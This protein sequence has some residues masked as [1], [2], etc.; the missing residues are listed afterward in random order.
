VHAQSGDPRLAI[1]A[2]DR[3]RSLSPF[4]PL[5]FGMLASR[6]LSLLRL[7]EHEEAA[8]W[9]LKA[10]SR[11]NAH[12][13][14]QAIAAI[15]LALAEQSDQARA[16]VARIRAKQPHYVA[17]DLLRAF[18]FAA[19]GERLMHAGARRIGF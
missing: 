8:R 14:I 13:H 9:A 10:V 3:S 15:S 11:P 19:D 1:D 18:R 2:C 17:D 5:Q 6:A 16:L 7:G 12:A 4:D